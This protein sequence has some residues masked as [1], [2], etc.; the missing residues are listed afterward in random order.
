[1][2]LLRYAGLLLVYILS[3]GH[4]PAA[5]PAESDGQSKPRISSK[6]SIRGLAS[7]ST[8]IPTISSL[9]SSPTAPAGIGPAF[10]P[11]PY[12]S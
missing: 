9:P 3:S 4:S 11:M 7:T 10:F 2:H 12:A 6:T 8:T 5:A 1:M